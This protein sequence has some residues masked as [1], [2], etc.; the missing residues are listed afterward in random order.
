[1]DP[2]VRVC[3]HSAFA[4]WQSSLTEAVFEHILT[5]VYNIMSNCPIYWKVPRILER[6]EP[7][8][9]RFTISG[10]PNWTY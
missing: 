10:A 3:R 1:M 9:R 8:W 5:G 6:K 4:F 7:Y 2:T